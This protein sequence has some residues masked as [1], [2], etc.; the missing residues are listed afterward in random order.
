[1]Q[2]REIIPESI[3]RIESIRKSTINIRIMVLCG[4]GRQTAIKSPLVM[5]T[6]SFVFFGPY[7]M[8]LKAYSLCLLEVFEGPH[9]MSGIKPRLAVYKSSTTCCTYCSSS[10]PYIL[11]LYNLFKF[12]LV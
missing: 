12:Y 4:L 6:I 2:K 9:G 5:K 10:K 3:R 8:M 11:N 1:M 7:L